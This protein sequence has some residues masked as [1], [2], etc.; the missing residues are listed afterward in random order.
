MTLVHDVTVPWWLTPGKCRGPTD[1][2]QVSGGKWWV[3]MDV[4]SWPDSRPKKSGG[5]QCE[6][7]RKQRPL[8][9]WI[10]F[11]FHTRL[12]LTLNFIFIFSCTHSMMSRFPVCAHVFRGVMQ[13]NKKVCFVKS[14]NTLHSVLERQRWEVRSS[15][16]AASLLVE[17]SW[18]CYPLT[19]IGGKL[20]NLFK[21]QF[22]HLEVVMPTL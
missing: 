22:P 13:V 14:A 19:G 10:T 16:S 2:G 9:F 21:P 12:K 1:P 18:L 11:P 6:A 8:S 20:S 15:D 5:C 4:R 17:K 3:H 7:L